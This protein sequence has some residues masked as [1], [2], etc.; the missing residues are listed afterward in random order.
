VDTWRSR[1]LCSREPAKALLV[2]VKA[3]LPLYV[4]AV[5]ELGDVPEGGP[6]EVVVSGSDVL[7][8]RGGGRGEGGWPV[9]F[10]L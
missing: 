8:S 7:V 6:V 3:A 1:A 10:A 4:A 5:L 9:R 2:S